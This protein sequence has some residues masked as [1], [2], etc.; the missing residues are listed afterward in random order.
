MD[1]SDLTCPVGLICDG[2]RCYFGCALESDCP[3]GTVCVDYLCIDR[4]VACD[5]IDCPDGYMCVYG[6]CLPYNPLT[7]GVLNL[8]G[9]LFVDSQGG[10]RNSSNDA[11]GDVTIYL[12]NESQTEINGFVTT[13]ADGNYSFEN[14][15]PGTYTIFVDHSPYKVKVDSKVILKPNIKFTMLEIADVGDEF[16]LRLSY[17]T[18]LEEYHD[19]AS[20]FRI[21]PN[22]NSGRIM[23]SSQEDIGEATVRVRDLTGRLIFSKELYISKSR[24]ILISNLVNQKQ[25]LLIIGIYK[26]NQLIHEKSVVFTPK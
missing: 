24:G 16:E 9:V 4:A 1:C 12:L 13:D 3:D 8:T 2:G 20:T 19:A 15:P 25:G 5:S 14:L 6:T 7:T 18:G 26:E 11:L 22:P 23:L 10:G 21:Y 17:V